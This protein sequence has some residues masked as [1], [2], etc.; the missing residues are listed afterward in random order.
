MFIFIDHICTKTNICWRISN[1]LVQHLCIRHKEV[2]EAIHYRK[3]KT[4]KEIVVISGSGGSIK[5][6]LLFF[7][8]NL[9][10][11]F[12]WYTQCSLSTMWND[13]LILSNY[14]EF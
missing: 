11:I 13:Y 2:V 6:Y 8:I 3:S 4:N 12:W 7:I 14:I 1:K 9:C 5:T 10:K